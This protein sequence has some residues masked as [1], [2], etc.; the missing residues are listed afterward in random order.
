MINRTFT[1]RLPK[2]DVQEETFNFL[3]YW[4]DMAAHSWGAQEPA[5]MWKSLKILYAF[6]NMRLDQEQRE[7]VKE[8]LRNVSDLLYKNQD[9]ID[10]LVMS[11][12]LDKL[13]DVWLTINEALEKA[14]ILF[15]M[16]VDPAELMKYSK[17]S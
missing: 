10:N 7:K 5:D 6:V 9:A 17:S 1:S 13:Y 16:R 12:A 4:S 2:E 8:E 11:E 3:A 14:G 15:K